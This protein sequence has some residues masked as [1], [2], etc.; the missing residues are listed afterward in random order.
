MKVDK[1][2]SC[3]SSSTYPRLSPCL[4]ASVVNI[5]INE[6]KSP[7]PPFQLA[8]QVSDDLLRHRSPARILNVPKYAS[9]AAWLAF[10]A[11]RPILRRA[12]LCLPR[13][14]N[15]HVRQARMA[16]QI[17]ATGAAWRGFGVR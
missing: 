4:S 2:R 9:G 5:F 17:R 15:R 11:P 1:A 14:I 3:S 6:R 12:I 16:G 8:A 7:H 10:L 13:E